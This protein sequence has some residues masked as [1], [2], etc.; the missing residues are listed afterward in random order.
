MNPPSVMITYAEQKG[1]LM[2]IG[3]VFGTL[4][5]RRLTRRDVKALEADLHQNHYPDA[6]RVTIIA[7]QFLDDEGEP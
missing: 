5:T 4:N 3:Q 2:S 1:D 7:W 6:D